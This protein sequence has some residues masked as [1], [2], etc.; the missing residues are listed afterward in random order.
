MTWQPGTP[1]LTAQDHLDWE[2]WRKDRKREGQRQ[3][4]ASNRRIDY[5]PDA[6]AAAAIDAHA[7]NWAGGDFSSVI[8][9]IVGEWV[10]HQRRKTV[11]QRLPP[12]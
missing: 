11:R 3:R 7:G 8:N 12:E 5:Y 10:E 2:Q 4:R 6:T 9:R 1:V